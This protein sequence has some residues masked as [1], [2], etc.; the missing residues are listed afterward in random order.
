[1]LQVKDRVMKAV[2]QEAHT[3]ED[4]GDLS[5]QTFFPVQ[6]APPAPVPTKPYPPAKREYEPVTDKHICQAIRKMKPWKAMRSGTAPNSVFTHAWEL[7]IPH[8]GPIF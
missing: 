7:L 3:N 4:K 1:M 5:Y 2:T 8:L 6:T